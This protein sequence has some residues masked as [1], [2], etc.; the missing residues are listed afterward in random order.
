MLNTVHIQLKKY[1]ARD[2]FKKNK[3]FL[4]NI[5]STKLSTKKQPLTDLQTRKEKEAKRKELI[6]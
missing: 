4:R 3:I 6:S 2:F 5:L 1:N